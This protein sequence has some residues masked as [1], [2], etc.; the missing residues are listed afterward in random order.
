MKKV[1]IATTNK[2]KYQAVTNI[3]KKTL[4]NEKE[5]EIVSQTKDMNIPEEKESGSCR[6]RARKKALNAY[7]YLKDYNYDYIVGLDDALVLRDRIE[8]NIKEY[9]SKIIFD[10]YLEDG[11]EY[12][13]KRAYCIIDKMGNLYEIDLDIPEIYHPLKKDFIIEDNTYPLSHVSY[14]IGFDKPVCELSNEE[15]TNYYLQFV[16]EG[17]LSL[18]IK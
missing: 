3:F 7:K 17:L 8:P 4:F 1:L 6:E 10:N 12:A 14:P 5:Y 11:E 18:K 15:I 2:D 9:I 16:K 13:F